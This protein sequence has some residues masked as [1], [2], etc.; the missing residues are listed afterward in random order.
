M[1]SDFRRVPIFLGL[2]SPTRL[3]VFAVLEALKAELESQK[4]VIN[5]SLTRSKFSR[6]LVHLHQLFLER[7]NASVV[8]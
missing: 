7:Y 6:C 3:A 2:A 5:W 1:G 8:I 4:L